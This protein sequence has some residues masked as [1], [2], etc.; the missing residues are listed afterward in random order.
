VSKSTSI[1]Y[2]GGLDA[3]DVVLPSRVVTFGRGETVELSAEEC[4]L[5]VAHPD[6]A[7]AGKPTKAAKADPS[8]ESD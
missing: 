6:F 4:A 8:T 2:V 7:E 1:E 3:V 5:L